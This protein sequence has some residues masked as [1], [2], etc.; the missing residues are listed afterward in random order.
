LSNSRKAPIREHRQ[1]RRTRR[2]PQQKRGARRREDILAATGR[3]LDREGYE[4]TTTT[5]IAAEAGTSVGTVYEYFRDRDALVRALLERYRERLRVAV[6]GALV[7]VDLAS[8]RRLAARGVDTFVEFYRQEP[9]YRVLWLESLT[10]PALRDASA[11]WGEEFSEIV[12]RLFT[13]LLPR[14]PTRRRRAI[15]R[16]T[17]HLVSGL[18]SMALAGPRDLFEPTVRETKRALESYLAAVIER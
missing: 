11:A 12:E 3:L 14:V 7:G 2:E 4:A 16:T 10:S 1:P 15:A 9:G 13:E 5:A 6:E 17:I 18:T 8:W